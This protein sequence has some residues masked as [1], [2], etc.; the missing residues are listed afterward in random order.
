MN[1]IRTNKL[2]Q[3]QKNDLLFLQET[4][5][6]HDHI[7]LTFPTEEDC[8]YYLLYNRGDLLSALCTFFNDH[9]A[10]QCYAYTLHSKR[11]GGLFTLLLKELLKDTGDYDLLFPIEE[12]CKDTVCTLNAL[13]ASF[14]YREYIMELTYSDFLKKQPLTKSRLE[15]SITVSAADSSQKGSAQYMFTKDGI[16][17][18]SC[19]L[20]SREYCAY[21]YGFEIKEE[22]RNQGL[23]STCLFLFLKLFFTEPNTDNLP[24]LLLQVSGQN[25]PAMTIYKKAGFRITESLS[26]YIY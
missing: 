24:K 1:I 7:S 22:L 6:N 21:V 25:Q 15:Q 16:R 12:S 20:D 8:H 13:N 2:S 11:Q 4:C 17:I 5:R 10:Y 14:W 19:F 26:Y 18:G 23:G 9:E 3:K